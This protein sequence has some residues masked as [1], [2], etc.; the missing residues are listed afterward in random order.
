[1]TA[2]NLT[3]AFAIH[4]GAILK[5]EI[6]YRGIS[7]SQLAKDMGIAYS[8]RKLIYPSCRH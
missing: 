7:Q 5:D 4:P 3:P 2:N 1:M 8:A 6:E